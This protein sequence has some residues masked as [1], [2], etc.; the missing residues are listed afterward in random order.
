VDAVTVGSTTRTSN[1][2]LDADRRGVDEAMDHAWLVQCVEPRLGDP[3]VGRHMRKWRKAG[4]LEAGPWRPP[5]AGTPP[6]GR[7]SPLLATRSRHDVLARWAA[8][9]RRRST[10]GDVMSGRYGDDVLVGCPHPDDATQFRR[11]L[12]ERVHRLHRARHPDK[13]RL[14]AGGRWANARRQRRGQGHPEPVDGRGW[15]PMCRQTR[16]GTWTVRRQTVAKRLRK[17][18]QEINQPLRERRPWPI[19]HLGAGLQ[20]V[21]TGPYRSSGGPR[22][23][24]MRRV[25]QER[26]LR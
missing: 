18:W 13:T 11:D 3:R 17:Q 21:L 16:P 22:N 20:R 2:V 12:R 5:A 8:Q 9:W 6:G 26:I 1:G 14:M 10:R 24:G 15:T 23:L 7:A 25:F 19:R 4:V